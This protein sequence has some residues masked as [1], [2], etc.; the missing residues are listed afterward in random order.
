MAIT[1]AQQAKQML[2]DGGRIGFFTGMREQEQREKAASNRES[3]RGGQYNTPKQSTYSSEIEDE[4]TSKDRKETLST[5]PKSMPSGGEA[6]TKKQLKDIRDKERRKYQNQF[7]SKGIVP[8]GPNLKARQRALNYTN[9]EIA[10]YLDRFGS[11]YDP[12]K[13]SVTKT[14][15]PNFGVPFPAS[16]IDEELDARKELK[17][18]LKT[19]NR[20]PVGKSGL[21]YELSAV[22]DLDI[23]SIRELAATQTL[24]QGAPLTGYQAK[25]LEDLKNKIETRDNFLDTGDTSNI[26][27]KPVTPVDIRATDPISTDPCKGPNPPAYCFVKEDKEEEVDPRTN[28]Y[29]LSP[30]IAG[31]MFDFSGFADGGRAEFAE[32]G[33]PYEGGIMD[34]ES[35]RQ[36]YFL[37]KLVKK[38][39]RALK[40]ITKSKIG[41]VALMGALGYGLGGGTFFGKMLPG[42]TRGGQGFGGF[43]GLKSILGNVGDMIGGSS[44]GDKFAK[45][46][47]NKIG[48]GILGISALSGLTAPKQENFD[49]EQYYK[50]GET[51][52]DV[53]PYNRIAGSEFDF[54]GSPKK[55]GGLMRLGFDEGG[56]DLST[57]ANYKGWKKLYEKNPDVAAMND[58][59]QQYLNFYERDKTKQAEGSKE[60]VAKKTMPLL[61]MD[62]MEKDY[63]EDG[64]FVPIGR[65]ER[66]DDVPARLSKNEFVFTADAVRNAGEG[67]IDKGAEVMYNM[68]KNLESGGEVS[69]ESQGLDGAREMFQT[70][71]RLGEVI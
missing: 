37:G 6:K 65:M 17:D 68:M 61:D 32:G 42:V 1:R 29:G 28:F 35:G 16:I 49:I 70:S 13:F 57:D 54:Y 53:V 36:M 8:P 52:D 7:T 58:N 10:R 46:A 48:M 66:A 64:G 67:D 14:G 38:A 27:P 63:R 11:Y 4:T 51:S 60:P 62:G 23:D 34:L 24:A 41:K 5:T 25:A 19:G 50:T 40:K 59:H 30:R 15:Y 18:I 45:F 44:L 22:P 12:N 33:M 26:Y 9:K 47:G 69:E 3:R 2:Q 21:S 20:I 55:D 31:S 39:S 43:G 56:K 71:Q